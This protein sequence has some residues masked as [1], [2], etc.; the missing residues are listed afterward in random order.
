MNTEIINQKF[1]IRVCSFVIMTTLLAL[2][3]SCNKNNDKI[4]EEDPYKVIS[5]SPVTDKIPYE[6]LGSGKIVFNRIS[7]QDINGFYII[8]LDNKKTSG[9][10]LINSSPWPSSPNISHDGTKIVCSMFT[11]NTAVTIDLIDLDGSNCHPISY[12]LSSQPRYPTW[13]PDGS[14][15]IFYT[16]DTD[17]GVLY[18]QSPVENANDT[19]VLTKFYYGDDDPNWFILPSGGFSISQEQ[20]IVCVSYGNKLNGILSIVPYIGKSGVSTLLPMTA[21]EAFESPVFSPD[22]LKIA[23]LSIEHDSL[24]WR[25]NSVAVKTMNP[26]GDNVTQLVKI[27][28]YKMTVQWAYQMRNWN[29]SL[30]WSPDG[31]KILFTV[32]MEEYGCHLFVINSDGSGLTQITDNINGYDVDVSWS[33]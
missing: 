27:N 26:D 6:V 14:K 30:C 5:L 10:K 7:L 17:Y 1:R 4:P 8:D 28:A 3:D 23:F 24:D 20:K 31:S 19:L 21:H 13:T 11:I 32:P 12:N 15:V 22:G 25:F 9:F 16:D 33:R 18:M 29:V 2:M